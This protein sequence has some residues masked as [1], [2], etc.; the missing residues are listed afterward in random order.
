[1]PETSRG[2]GPGS[3]ELI[4]ESDV[5]CMFVELDNTVSITEGPHGKEGAG[6]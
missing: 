3:N 6:G 2:T 4:M 5:D 1:M